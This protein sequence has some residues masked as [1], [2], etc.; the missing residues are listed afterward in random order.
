[1]K[2]FFFL[3][4]ISFELQAAFEI[5]HTEAFSGG[6][7]NST[8]ATKNFF[9]AFLLNPAVTAV[10]PTFNVGLSYF[11]PFGITELNCGNFI[12]NFRFKDIGFG[13]SVTN[14]GNEIYRE[15][16][17]TWNISRHL[18]THKM[19]LGMNL[20]WY[21]IRVENYQSAQAIGMDVGMQYAINPDLLVAMSVQ[22]VNNPSL[23]HHRNE[24]PVVFNLGLAVYFDDKFCSNIAF[25]KDAWLP[26]SLHFGISYQANTSFIL[27]SGLHTDPTIPTVGFSFKRKGVAI[28]YALHYHFSLGA[29]HLWGL[30]FTY[31]QNDSL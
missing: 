25:R 11:R 10:I 22:N 13:F 2:K 9:S 29:T 8:V 21:T 30:S 5:S 19:L 26:A 16:R 28:H 17:F 20:N 3:I 15:N 12:S 7:V 23:L 18:L 27:H 6:L 14:L 1:M 24:L 4:L 31:K